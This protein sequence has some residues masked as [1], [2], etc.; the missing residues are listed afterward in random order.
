MSAIEQ[1]IESAWWIDS[2]L[3]SLNSNGSEALCMTALDTTK[4]EEIIQVQHRMQLL[5]LLQHMI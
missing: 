4:M 3:S 1:D 5:L 2:G